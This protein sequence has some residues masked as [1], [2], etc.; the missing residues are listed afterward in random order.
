MRFHLNRFYEAKELLPPGGGRRPSGGP[1]G[2]RWAGGGGGGGGRMLPSPGMP[3]GVPGGALGGGGGPLGTPRM[4]ASPSI[5]RLDRVLDL[6]TE[7]EARYRE[8]E[9]RLAD[10]AKRVEGAEDRVRAGEERAGAFDAAGEMDH[11]RAAIEQLHHQ[12]LLVGQEVQVLHKDAKEARQ[13]HAAANA[14]VE[15]LERRL[16]EMQDGQDTKLRDMKATYK[17]LFADMAGRLAKQLERLGEQDKGPK[18]FETWARGELGELRRLLT[19]HTREADEQRAEQQRA[20]DE[21]A[22]RL[23]E[24]AAAHDKVRRR[25]QKLEQGTSSLGNL[26][27]ETGQLQEQVSELKSNWAS[28]AKDSADLGTKLGDT[29]KQLSDVERTVVSKT[30]DISRLAESLGTVLRGVGQAGA[31]GA[32]APA[33][34]PG[35]S[36]PPQ[37]YGVHL[38]PGYPYQNPGAVGLQ[39]GSATQGYSA[40][41]LGAPQVYVQHESLGQFDEFLKKLKRRVREAERMAAQHRQERRVVGRAEAGGRLGSV[42][43]ESEVERH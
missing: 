4:A 10:L 29:Q 39:A 2:Q 35:G 20:M 26:K 34:P 14:R 24:I 8:Q 9:I 25:C 43:I 32:G 11:A 33:A 3:P 30:R 6:V 31:G 36:Q 21:A 16:A 7:H 13:G 19:D 23:G 38:P 40:P 37:S 17:Q 15:A 1:R 12:V 27:G 42:N 41:G 5:S 18:E 22:R 28:V